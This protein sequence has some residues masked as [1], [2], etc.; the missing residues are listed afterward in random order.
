MGL[1]PAGSLEPHVAPA[2]APA[3]REL[4]RAAAHVG[5]VVELALRKYGR[6]VVD[7]QLLLNRL[8][9]AAIDAYTTAAVLSRASRAH[10]LALPSAPH[11]VRMDT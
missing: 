9:A 8:A 2:L 1:A 10:R 6:R 3:A 7:E 11:E 5:A 4:V